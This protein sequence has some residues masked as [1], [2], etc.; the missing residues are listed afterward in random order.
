MKTTTHLKNLLVS[1][2]GNEFKTLID[3]VVERTVSY[4]EE[5]NPVA[6][7]T[8]DL[9]VPLMLKDETNSMLLGRNTK[10]GLLTT[11]ARTHKITHYR[12]LNIKRQ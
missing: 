1:E 5:W 11:L 2:F 8:P 4:V 6:E 10:V 7:S 3:M 12:P 9:D